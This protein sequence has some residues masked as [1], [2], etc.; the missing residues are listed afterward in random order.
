[1]EFTSFAWDHYLICEQ[2]CE[3]RYVLCSGFYGMVLKGHKLLYQ[4]VCH[5]QLWVF[6]IWRWQIRLQPFITFYYQYPPW[7]MAAPQLWM[8]CEANVSIHPNGE[9]SLLE[10]VSSLPL[11]TS[12]KLVESWLL[13]FQV[14]DRLSS[15]VASF[16]VSRLPS[17]ACQ[18]QLSSSWWSPPVLSASFS[19]L[20]P[21]GPALHWVGL[22]RRCLLCS[23]RS[24]LAWPACRVPPAQSGQVN[25]SR[26]SRR[27]IWR[28][29]AQ[30]EATSR[31]NRYCVSDVSQAV[32]R[33]RR[34]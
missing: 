21:V 34:Q 5:I 33:A 30:W 22:W 15:R 13:L 28:P 25:V 9:S 7:Q 23:A 12:F 24:G 17:S 31:V 1:M 3:Y 2:T 10:P 19:R 32:S 4:L 14:R 20:R 29:T 8:N 11:R 16:R 26:S 18:F 27:Y 6:F